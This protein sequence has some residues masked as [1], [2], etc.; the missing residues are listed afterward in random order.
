[1]F[2][3]KSRRPVRIVLQVMMANT[4]C[5]QPRTERD[6]R[7]DELPGDNREPRRDLLFLLMGGDPPAIGIVCRKWRFIFE[8]AGWL[9]RNA[10]RRHE[11]RIG[12]YGKVTFAAKCSWRSHQPPPSGTLHPL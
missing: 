7:L 1:M 12:G 2:P 11:F 5:S 6:H 3:G 4:V 8:G 9:Y 10:R